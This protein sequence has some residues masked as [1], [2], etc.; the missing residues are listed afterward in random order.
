MIQEVKTIIKDNMQLHIECSTEL[1]LQIMEFVKTQDNI[2]ILLKEE[3]FYEN[4]KVKEYLMFFAETLGKKDMYLKAI[5]MMN[6]ADLQYIKLSKCTV[7]QKK[8]IAIA[9][10]ILKDANI[11]YLQE[12]ISEIDQDS[13]KI[14]LNWMDSC[15]HTHKHIITTSRSLKEVC[16]CPGAHFYMSLQKIQCIDKNEESE[17]NQDI[18]TLQKL[19][20]KSNEKIFLFNP[21]E[22]DYVEASDGRTCVYVRGDMYVSTLTMEEIDTKL[23]RFGFYR[24]HRSYLVNMQ[25][26]VEIV[27]WTRNSYSLK[28][29]NYEETMVPLSKTKIQE[30]KEI[31]QF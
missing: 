6:L 7:G 26:V 10:E 8:R 23:Q 14:I 4:M 27:K 31:Y 12:P 1:S 3:Y 25:K 22:V 11:Y 2:S 20:V 17:D 29:M 16:L 13:I 5:D 9:R 30:M 24:S 19:M 18:P 15:V 21:E 28:L